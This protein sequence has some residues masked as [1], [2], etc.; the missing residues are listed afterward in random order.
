MSI[1]DRLRE[2]LG[3]PAV[4]R[5][6]A[7]APRAVPPSVEALASVMGTAHEEGWRVRV[8]GAGS[9]MPAEPNADVLVSTRGL[10]RVL[11]VTGEDLVASAEGGAD[12]ETL[13]RALA[14]QG[15]WLALDPPG[16]PDRTLGSVIVTGTAGPLRAGYGPVRDHI[17]GCTVVTGDGRVVR[18]GG[19]VVKN[20]AGY[21]LPKLMAGGFGA[22]GVV[23]EVHLRLRAVPARDVTM[24]AT[25]PRDGLTLAARDLIEGG[26]D[27]QALELLSPALAGESDWTLACRVLGTEDGTAE[28]VAEL[29]R[30]PN[31]GW[32]EL[33][34]ERTHAFWHVTARAFA[35]PPLCLRLGVLPDG[36]DET[37][38]LLE[39][40]LGDG[41]ASA[42]C[43]AGGLR[44]S[45][46]ADAGA[47][48]D[49]RR[50][51][52]TR[53][54]PLTVERAAPSLLTRVGHFG[55]YREGVAALVAR[56]RS[57]FDPRGRLQVALDGRD[58]G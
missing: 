42:S 58:D 5:S 1:A 43:A 57:A 56:L 26:L 14:G 6:L 17:L 49:L 46:E 52:A 54:I 3:A 55:A 22:F 30:T 23:A 40:T 4:E 51:L 11:Q 36:L 12:L 29:A 27:A 24:V 38:D 34:A 31:L 25:G 2:L 39:A 41:L 35:G 53:E 44:W 19:R 45:G 7:G 10:D 16:R 47:I 32:R 28:Q 13:R 33:P 48:R 21:D 50:T 18:P 15:M 20:V 37:L 9:W 8:E